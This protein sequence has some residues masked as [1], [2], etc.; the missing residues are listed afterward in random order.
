[1]VQV[2]CMNTGRTPTRSK[3]NPL[4][5][6]FEHSLSELENNTADKQPRENTWVDVHQPQKKVLKT[7]TLL[8]GP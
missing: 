1:M 5:H 3:Q 2:V 6:P 4:K 8:H 7:F